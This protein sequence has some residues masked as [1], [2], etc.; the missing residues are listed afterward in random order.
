MKNRLHKEI[1]FRSVYIVIASIALLTSLG[2][3]TLNGSKPTFDVFFFE[4]YFNT[5]LV[6]TLFASA[7]ALRDA[8]KLYSENKLDEYV[9]RHPYLRFSSMTAMVFG[10]IMG[11]FFVGRIGDNYLVE[12]LKYSAIY[13]GV[14]TAGYWTDL[15][16]LL[17]RLVCPLMYIIGYF[18][19]D[20]RGQ[21]KKIHGSLG[22]IPPTVFYMFNKFFCKFYLKSL[23]GADAAMAS[24]KYAKAAPYFFYDDVTFYQKWWPLAW[25]AIFGLGLMLINR[26]SLMLANKERKTK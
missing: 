7:F 11:L 4:N 8:K 10:L 20:A 16:V 21:L 18:K 6:L 26:I 2:I 19:F 13:P 14:I 23:G 3:F 1:V 17:S 9:T 15:S 22:I 5:P 12:G 25:L 24:G